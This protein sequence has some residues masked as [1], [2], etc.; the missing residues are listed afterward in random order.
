MTLGLAPSQPDLFR[1]RTGFYEPRVGA[2]SIHGLLHRK[3]GR[4]FPD[5]VFADLFTDVAAGP[6][7]R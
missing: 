7:R 2:D 3:C 5:E 4:L 6:C 1:S